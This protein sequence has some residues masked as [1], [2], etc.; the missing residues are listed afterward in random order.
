[1]DVIKKNL[2]IH[3]ACKNKRN[4]SA[5][6]HGNGTI[7]FMILHKNHWITWKKELRWG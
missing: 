7:S 4:G 6:M 3:F 2:I 5:D 1:V